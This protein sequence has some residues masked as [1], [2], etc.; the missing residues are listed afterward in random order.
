MPLNPAEEKNKLYLGSKPKSDQ[1][2]LCDNISGLQPQTEGWT[3]MSVY[4][5]QK[6]YWKTKY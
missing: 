1:S 3:F 2:E 4:D 5:K 6:N